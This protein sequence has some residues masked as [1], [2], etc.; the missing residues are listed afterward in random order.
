MRRRQKAFAVI[1]SA[2]T[3]GF[4][5]L[6]LA[7]A[8]PTIPATGDADESGWEFVRKVVPPETTMT[9]FT[10]RRLCIWLNRGAI[11]K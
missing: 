8:A 6:V 11:W 9:M 5:V 4:V 2:M 10:G 3:M 1:G 7:G